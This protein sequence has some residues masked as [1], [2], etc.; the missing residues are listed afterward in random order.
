M[1]EEDKDMQA[2]AEEINKILEKY[3]YSLEVKNEVKLKKITK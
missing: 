1:Q 3:G 2:C